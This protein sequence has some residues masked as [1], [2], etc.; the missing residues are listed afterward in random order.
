MFNA[1]N[2]QNPHKIHDVTDD[3]VVSISHSFLCSASSNF[4]HITMAS[5]DDG[6]FPEYQIKGYDFE[7]LATSDA[8]E[9]SLSLAHSEQFSDTSSHW[10]DGGCIGNTLI[11]RQLCGSKTRGCRQE[12]SCVEAKQGD[13]DKKSAVWKQNKGMLTRRQLCGSKTRGC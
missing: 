2:S 3:S 8:A 1:F 6:N 11:R 12:V 10:D 7:P 5:G 9:S 4:T 13:A